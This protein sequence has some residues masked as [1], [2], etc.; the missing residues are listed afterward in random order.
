MLTPN[1]EKLWYYT[2]RGT[3]IGPVPFSDFQLAANSGE[4]SRASDKAWCDSLVEWIEVK[5][6]EG[7]FSSPPPPFCADSV[8]VVT[9]QSAG[10]WLRGIT[11]TAAMFEYLRGALSAYNFIKNWELYHRELLIAQPIYVLSSIFLGTFLLMIFNR[12]K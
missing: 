5:E 4:I 8:S 2:T 3:T 10:S 11:L 6:I 7:L 12:Q 9:S 1:R